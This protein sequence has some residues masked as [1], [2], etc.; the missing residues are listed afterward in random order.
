MRSFGIVPNQGV[1]QLCEST[2][3]NCWCGRRR[4]I[5]ALSLWLGNQTSRFTAHSSNCFPTFINLNLPF[6]TY[7]KKIIP[8][9]L[10]VLAQLHISRRSFARI[11]ILDFLNFLDTQQIVEN[12][13]LLLSISI[14]LYMVAQQHMS[15]RSFP[16][17]WHFWFTELFGHTADCWN[18]FAC[19]IN[20]NLPLHGAQL[21][22]CSVNQKFQIRGNPSNLELLIYW[23][24]A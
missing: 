9:H 7:F 20:L 3:S 8:W 13:L 24:E 6:T 22:I 10:Y 12:V 5:P 4:N 19:F 15:R 21:H 18:S 23:T 17:I 2:L 16:R 1:E 11:W 14:Y